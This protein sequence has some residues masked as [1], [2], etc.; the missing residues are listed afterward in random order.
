MTPTDSLVRRLR[1][2]ALMLELRAAASVSRDAMLMHVKNALAKYDADCADE[3][4]AQERD[5][6]QREDDAGWFV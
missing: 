5:W 2:L 4:A 1:E 6:Q 3:H